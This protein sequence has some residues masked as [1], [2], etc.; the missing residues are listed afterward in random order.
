MIKLVQEYNPDSGIR[1]AVI[2]TG[3]VLRSGLDRFLRQL[4]RQADCARAAESALEVARWAGEQSRMLARRLDMHA[5][6]R[7]LAVP[8]RGAPVFILH[9]DHGSRQDMLRAILADMSRNGQ[10]PLSLAEVCVPA[11][12]D[13]AVLLEEFAELQYVGVVCAG[14]QASP[15]LRWLEGRLGPFGQRAVVRQAS[16]G[17]VAAAL[18]PRALDI[19]VLD[20]QGSD[21]GAP[22]VARDIELWEARVKPGGVLA[23]HG[24]GGGARDGLEAVCDRR[25]GND[26]HLGLGDTF[27]WYVEP[28]EEE[29]GGVGTH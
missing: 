3:R 7:T 26:I 6:V 21:G 23:G 5:W 2:R 16:S 10:R 18:P 1:S 11:R 13:P 9:D 20:A 28:E 27:W 17:D 19:A 4:P 22:R 14:P 25:L 12:A 24:L 8:G 15:L 29:D